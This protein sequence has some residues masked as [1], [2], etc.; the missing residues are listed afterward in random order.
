MILK[1]AD[2]MKITEPSLEHEVATE[3]RLLYG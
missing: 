1:E 2:R 3:G